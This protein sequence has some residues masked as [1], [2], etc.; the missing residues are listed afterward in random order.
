[1]ELSKS[2]P[3]SFLEKRSKKGGGSQNKNTQ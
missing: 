2:A 3:S 1:M